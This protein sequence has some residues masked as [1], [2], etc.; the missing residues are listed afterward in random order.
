M[1]KQYNKL[2]RDRIP[3]IIEQDGR[4]CETATLEAD[5]YETKLLEKLR[6]ETLELEQADSQHD[7]LEEIADAMEVL[8]ALTEYY[9]S[10][11]EEVEQTRLKKRTER[12]GFSQRKLLK[13]VHD[14]GSKTLNET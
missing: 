11:S 10:T 8:Y 4:T 2:V 13:Q 5:D 9:G 12:G 14:T 6:E 1:I 3:A 7:K